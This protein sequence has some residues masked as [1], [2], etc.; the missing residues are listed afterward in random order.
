MK[1]NYNIKINPG[2]VRG[3]SGGTL[4]KKNHLYFTLMVIFLVPA[5]IWGSGQTETKAGMIVPEDAIAMLHIDMEQTLHTQTTVT[6]M[7]LYSIFQG[8]GKMRDSAG[9]AMDKE[10]ANT[11]GIT[12]EK[13]KTITLFTLS[14]DMSKSD[15][16][17]GMQMRCV[18][19]AGEEVAAYLKKTY[20][21][22]ITKYNKTSYYRLMVRNQELFV[23]ITG[24]TILYA[25]RTE[26]LE[27]MIDVLYGGPSIRNNQ[28]LYK[29]QQKCKDYPFYAVGY[30]GETDHPTLPSPFDQVR[31]FSLTI[32]PGEDLSFEFNGWMDAPSEAEMFISS[33]QGG[34]A[35]F[36]MAV[37]AQNRKAYPVLQ[38]VIK[39][40]TY[41]QKGKQAIISGQ[42]SG[43]DLKNIIQQVP[44]LLQLVQ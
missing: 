10:L 28:R 31:E 6:I 32:T 17:S 26:V 38:A 36:S 18:P 3:F 20:G 35:L 30:V 39:G 8:K 44:S 4:M 42:L 33:V 27:K 41:E 12:L 1:M 5:I 22:T 37:M 23:H 9:E 16:P 29:L 15:A 7:E 40:I 34:V 43:G 11:F 13:I 14:L 2:A 21:P 25:N 19:G 24:E